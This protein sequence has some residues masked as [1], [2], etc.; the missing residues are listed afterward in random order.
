MDKKNGF[1]G[2]G[3]GVGYVSVMIIFAV[4]CLTIFAVLSF[5][6][7][8]SGDAFNERSGEYL[9]QYYIADAQAK[10]TLAQLNEIAYSAVRSDF[11]EDSFELSAG[12][13]EGVSLKKSMKGYEAGFSV[14][15]NDRQE[16]AVRADFFADGGYEILRWQ[17]VDISVENSGSHLNVWDGSF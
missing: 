16:L 1:K 13:I 4:I 17:S 15:I 10:E 6:A 3:L 5:R 7:A 11:F 12:E 9:K 8:S 14:K 2:A